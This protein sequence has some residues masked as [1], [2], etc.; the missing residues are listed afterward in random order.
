[1]NFHLF[2]GDIDV[3][4]AVQTFKDKL[5]Q[6]YNK[7]CP[8]HSKRISYNRFSK[9]WITNQHMAAITRKHHLFRQYKQGIATF[10]EYNSHK[11]QVTRTLRKAKIGYFE[12]KFRSSFGNAKSTWSLID[13]LTGK[14]RKRESPDRIVSGTDVITD[15]SRIANSFNEYFSK[16]AIDLKNKIPNIDTAPLD[17]M[18]ERVPSSFFVAPVD[19]S[20]VKSTIFQLKNKSTGLQSV[21]IF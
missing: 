14:R 3:D 18:G 16:V 12:E 2:L 17:L 13:S 9:P 10:D 19:F 20:D 8:I 21:P 1:M 6:L 7:C 5:Y 15:P 4:V 11:N